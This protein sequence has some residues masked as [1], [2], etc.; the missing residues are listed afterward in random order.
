MKAKPTPG[1]E[2]TADPYF[3]RIKESIIQKT[4]LAYYED[5]EADLARILKARLAACGLGDCA[6]YAAFL[7]AGK[8]GAAEMDEL[9]SELTIGETY[10]FRHPEV[11][12]ALTAHV[13]PEILSRNGASQCLRI[14]SAGCS[15][16]AEPYSISIL[17]ARDFKPQLK[18][19]RIGVFGTDID[20]KFLA[21][22]RSGIYQDWAVRATSPEERQAYF[23]RTEQGWQLRPVY[24]EPVTFH[25]HNLIQDPLP[26]PALGLSGL[27]VVLCRN[28]A[29]YFSREQIFQLMERFHAALN[30][31]G[32]LITGP[33]EIGMDRPPG[34]QAVNLDGLIVYRKG[35]GE[36]QNSP[37]AWT[38][39]V[40]PGIAQDMGVAALP[41]PPSH[42]APQQDLADE[43]ASPGGGGLEEEQELARLSERGQWIAASGPARRLLAR[44]ETGQD[45]ALKAIHVLIEIND[46][47][48]AEKA[49][50]RMLFVDRKCQ[51][52]YYHLGL[53]LSCRGDLKMAKKAFKNAYDLAVGLP[54]DTPLPGG[55][56]LT[57]GQ[58]VKMAGLRAQLESGK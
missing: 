25:Y 42:D 14:W 34:F 26:L 19:W 29:I 18:G 12:K 37:P 46:F 3:P 22:A 55:E 2:V 32:W 1:P 43:D 7:E 23:E 30:D 31:G 39:P 47:D 8:A 45:A 27:D 51:M 36:L 57:A 54:A 10:F 11:F 4:G 38:P 41:V 5:K 50:R 33:A 28:V 35:G 52:A 6:A 20:K 48:G 15:S 21:Q 24:R 9:V 17:L 16:G 13:V 40:L 53:L 49:L 56:G 58:L 44:A